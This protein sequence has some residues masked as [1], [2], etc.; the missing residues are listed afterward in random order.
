ML[1]CDCGVL[2]IWSCDWSV[3]AFLP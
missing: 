2:I 1:L 3:F